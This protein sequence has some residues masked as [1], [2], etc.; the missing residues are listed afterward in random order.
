MAKRKRYTD[1]GQEDGSQQGAGGGDDYGNQSLPVAVLPPDFDGIPMD[2]ATYLAMVRQ[3]AATH[4]SVYTA[5]HNPYAVI[6]DAA[7]TSAVPVS[8]T[9]ELGIPNDEWRAAFLERFK[10]MREVSE[11]AA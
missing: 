5:T 3:E 2:G 11:R 10:A 4:P 9:T 1:N 8:R 7:S 6:A